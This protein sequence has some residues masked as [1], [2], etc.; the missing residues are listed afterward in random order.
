MG[1]YKLPW[2]HPVSAA[3]PTWDVKDKDIRNEGQCSHLGKKN[4]SETTL[5]GRRNADGKPPHLCVK[6]EGE[7]YRTR[8]PALTFHAEIIAAKMVIFWKK[9]SKKTSLKISNVLKGKLLQSQQN[10]LQ[11][12]WQQQGL[13]RRSQLLVS[14]N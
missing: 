11:A 1:T 12:P 10:Q 2:P 9:A 5:A 14:L 6:P 13:P 3:Q 8:P 4:I 7:T